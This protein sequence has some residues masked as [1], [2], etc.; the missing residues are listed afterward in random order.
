VQDL[1]DLG[2]SDADVLD[3]AFAAGA[4]CFFATVLDA[5]G[6]QA[7]RELADVLGPEVS[8]LLTVGRPIAGQP[9]DVARSGRGNGCHRATG[10]T[11]RAA[12]GPSTAMS[13]T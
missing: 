1:R 10:S 6:A 3:V 9:A 2:L 13:S 8:A 11:T 12:I 7:D 4:R 5:V